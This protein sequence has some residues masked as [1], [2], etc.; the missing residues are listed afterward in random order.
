MQVSFPSL[1][2]SFALQPCGQCG[3]SAELRQDACSSAAWLA[4]PELLQG[5]WLPVN[6]AGG[7]QCQH[8]RSLGT[9]SLHE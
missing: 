4:G 2:V 8:S 1:G 3:E 5:S 9:G 7:M 6:S